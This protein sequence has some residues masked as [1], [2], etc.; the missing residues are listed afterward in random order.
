MWRWSCQRRWKSRSVALTAGFQ[1]LARRAEREMACPA[2]LAERQFPRAEA[3]AGGSC[4]EQGSE[5]SLSVTAAR[6]GDEVTTGEPTQATE[7]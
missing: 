5:L 3:Q 4:L 2:R 6:T 7:R 1:T